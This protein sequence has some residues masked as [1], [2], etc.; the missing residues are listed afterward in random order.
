MLDRVI[1]GVTG[2]ITG[3]IGGLVGGVRDGYYEKDKRRGR[4]G[5]GFEEHREVVSRVQTDGGYS[6]RHTRYNHHKRLPAHHMLPNSNVEEFYESRQTHH[7]TALPYQ[8]NNY[9]HNGKM[10]NGWQGQHEDAYNDGY[11]GMKQ[12]NRLMAPQVPT[13]QVYMNPIQDGRYH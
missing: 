1:G 2:G 8:S 7:T 13:R 3:G 11:G 6:D 5:Y 10:G 12:Q 4:Y 9:H